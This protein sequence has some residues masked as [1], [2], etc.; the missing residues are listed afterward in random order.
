MAAVNRLVKP[1]GKTLE[2][3][4]P[5]RRPQTLLAVIPR[6]LQVLDTITHTIRPRISDDALWVQ[7]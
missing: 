6:I 3:N 4:R 7:S 1:A 2:Q 5:L